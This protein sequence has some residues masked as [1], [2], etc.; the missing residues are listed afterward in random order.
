MEKEMYK[1]YVILSTYRI[2]EIVNF[3]LKVSAKKRKAIEINFIKKKVLLLLTNF[4]DLKKQFNLSL[5][6][7]LKK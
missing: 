3:P 5:I 7:T 2:F 6:T 1:T 4:V